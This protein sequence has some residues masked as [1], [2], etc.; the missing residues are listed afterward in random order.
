MP[1][2]T[3]LA[4]PII[5]RAESNRVLLWLATSE[6]LNLGAQIYAINTSMRPP[7]VNRGAPL[8]E[9]VALRRVQ[10][11][12]RLFVH[13]IAV[14]PRGRPGSLFPPRTILAYDILELSRAG[15]ITSATSRRL[16]NLLNIDDVRLNPFPLPTFVLQRPNRNEL[17]ALYASCRK[18][19]G[20]GADASA[21]AI[22]LVQDRATSIEQRPTA[23][24]LGG[25]QIYADDVSDLL[26]AEIARLGEELQGA[27][28]PLPSVPGTAR[29]LRIGARQ[30]LL[31]REAFFTSTEAGNHLMTFGEFAATYLLA[32]NPD[33]WPPR[34]PNVAEVWRRLATETPMQTLV[35]RYNEQRTAL[36]DALRAGAGLRKVLANTPTY[37]IFDDHEITDDWNLNESWTSVVTGR[38]LGVRIIS[39]GLAAFWAFQGWG[40]APEAYPPSSF[41][42]VIEDRLNNLSGSAASYERLL[43]GFQQ[44]TFTAPTQPSTVFLD[45]RTG[46]EAGRSSWDWRHLRNRLALNLHEVLPTRVPRPPFPRNIQDILPIARRVP[47]HGNPAQLMGAS[48]RR[49]LNSLLTTLPSHQPVIFI[50]AA[51]VFGFEIIENVQDLLARIMGSYEFDLEHW[52]ANPDSMLD[53]MQLV[54]RRAPNPCVVLSGDVH[55][56]FEGIGE[57]VGSGVTMRVGQFTSSAMKNQTLAVMSV[58]GMVQTILSALNIF[59]LINHRTL[60][61]RLGGGVNHILE[62]SNP[63]DLALE[64]TVQILR[65]RRPDFRESIDFQTLGWSQAFNTVLGENNIGELRV[66]NRDVT[67]R[68][69]FARSG[70]GTTST[71][72]HRM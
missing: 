43:L 50:A 7:T 1:L 71:P 41:I 72:E 65:G 49:R 28:E 15:D 69:H 59:S 55:Y 57:V 66:R 29:S 31:D 22:R 6:P 18:L 4:G 62:V 60:Y 25:D 39:N 45:S 53:F 56:A 13:L 46:R 42:Q 11:G 48:A 17:V 33:I 5:R 70:G 52:H 64:A 34:L 35:N 16:P 27:P 61:W 36:D 3:V 23:F 21:A 24:F 44:W 54:L 37:M 40:N 26:I 58:A 68:L 19:H 67:H 32:W 14:L 10:L 8:G 38:P 12:A 51:P 9:G 30:A 20:K 2:P 47:L 63:I